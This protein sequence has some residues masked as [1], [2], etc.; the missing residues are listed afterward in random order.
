MPRQISRK[1]ADSL[2]RKAVRLAEKSGD[3]FRNQE[4]LW[5]LMVELSHKTPKKVVAVSASPTGDA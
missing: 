4:F 1:A 2:C 5:R 3:I